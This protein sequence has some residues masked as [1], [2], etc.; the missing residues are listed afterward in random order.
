ME[1]NVFYLFGTAAPLVLAAAIGTGLLML[2]S[3]VLAL[4]PFAPATAMAAALRPVLK[5][6]TLAMLPCAF[7]HF[8]RPVPGAGDNLSGVAILGA[9]GGLVGEARAPASGAGRSGRAGLAEGGW[10]AALGPLADSTELLLL[11]TSSEEA[12]LRGAKR[13][14][15]RHA[16]DLAALPTAVL[17]LEYTAHPQHLSVI[18]AE[19]FPGAVHDA[20]LVRLAQRAAATALN[21]SLPTLRLPLGA[22]DAA[23][24]TAAGVA[25]VTLQ[26]VDVGRLP[27]EYHTRYDVLASVEPEALERQ[28][29]LLLHCAAGIGRGDW[30]GAPAVLRARH[31]LPPHAA[32]GAAR[33]GDGEL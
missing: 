15:A 2:L 11:A 23:A 6:G 5:L 29:A 1:F 14:V 17:V 7:W 3:T 21:I 22:T 10:A 9:F 26:G 28:L 24:F 33:E 27:R 18:A 30:A 4:L 25:A 12:G 31:G 19:T 32:A 16:A 13:F 8:G 20:S